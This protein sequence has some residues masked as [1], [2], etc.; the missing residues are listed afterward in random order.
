M[1][2]KLPLLLFSALLA[3]TACDTKQGFQANDL[4]YVY[5]PSQLALRPHFVIFHKNDEITEVDYRIECSDLLYV[6][7]SSTG[8]YE[9][10]A[11]LDYSLVKSFEETT[12]LDSGT[13]IIKDASDD[14][15]NKVM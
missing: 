2:W 3:L 6:R 1:R 11:R 13:V 14:I 10:E 5:N 15:P 9:S 12:I 4:S 8:Q 7:N